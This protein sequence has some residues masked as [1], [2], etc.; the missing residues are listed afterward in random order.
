MF[1]SVLGGRYSRPLQN[2]GFQCIPAV[3]VLYLLRL[4]TRSALTGFSSYIFFGEQLTIL[5]R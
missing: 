2:L 4:R 5:D 3:V 1:K